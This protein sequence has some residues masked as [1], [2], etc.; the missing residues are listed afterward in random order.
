MES[1][2]PLCRSLFTR[3]T[4]FSS[5]ALVRQIATL[6][7]VRN[8]MICYRF[9]R[10]TLSLSLSRAARFRPPAKVAIFIFRRARKR[11]PVFIR[12]RY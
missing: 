2:P 11:P 4:L 3:I 5:R 9:I 12:D 10:L 7:S 6:S 8:Q 1:P